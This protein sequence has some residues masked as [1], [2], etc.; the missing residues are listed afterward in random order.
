MH[1]A[2]NPFERS[3]DDNT[4]VASVAHITKAKKEGTLPGGQIFHP[5]EWGDYLLWKGHKV[6][7]ASHTHLVPREVWNDY[8]T[9]INLGN[10][11][12]EI[13]DRYS[14]NV[15]LVDTVQHRGLME[16]LRRSS[17]W[18]VSYGNPEMDAAD[19]K[20]FVFYRVNPL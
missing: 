17:E 7:V 8:R 19:Q 12:K 13:L 20:A 5:Q 11:W 1:G 10:G 9:A 3:V 2:R 16:S 15:V 6:F 18:E 4:P 14:V